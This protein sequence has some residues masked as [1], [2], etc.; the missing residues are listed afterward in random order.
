MRSVTCW[1]NTL[2]SVTQRVI[3]PAVT[4]QSYA[5]GVKPKLCKDKTQS[6]IKE[7][8]H[9]NELTTTSHKLLN[10]SKGRTGRFLRASLS[11]LHKLF[12]IRK[13]SSK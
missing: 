12:Y 11:L 9:S 4:C 3:E 10:I 5:L 13:H 2:I 1:L 8:K 7:F 6:S